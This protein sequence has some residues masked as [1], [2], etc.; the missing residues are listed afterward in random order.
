[1]ALAFPTVDRPLGNLNPLSSSPAQSLPIEILQQIFGILCDDRP[2]H[3]DRNI[4][5][6]SQVTVSHVC[7]RWRCA[8]LDLSSI[9]SKINVVA[10]DGREDSVT[11]ITALRLAETLVS[12]C[13]PAMIE[14]R[15][16]A[17][18]D[19][20]LN[21]THFDD[22]IRHLRLEGCPTYIA[23][24]PLYQQRILSKTLET[25]S[26]NVFASSSCGRTGPAEGTA[27]PVLIQP[28]LP[29]PGL[30]LLSINRTFIFHLPMDL[31]GRE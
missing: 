17:T 4:L 14:L 6:S 22:R 13:K 5:E 29:S 9:W 23:N 30:R 28:I 20:L 1:M 24:I 16:W 18:H 27:M 31:S 25:L 10:G 12:C 26:L 7:G 21:Q 15:W 2:L 8:A 19:K 3:L 11:G